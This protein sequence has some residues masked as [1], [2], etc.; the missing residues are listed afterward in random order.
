MLYFNNQQLVLETFRAVNWNARRSPR[1]Y[2]D[3]LRVR[4]AHL[5]ESDQIPHLLKASENV[6]PISSKLARPYPICR[7][8][9]TGLIGV[10][11]RL[12]L[13]APRITRL[14]LERSPTRA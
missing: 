11:S 1:E 6:R 4:P 14:S 13:L 12:F 5:F 8:F 3:A 9:I 2:S 10:L 7:V